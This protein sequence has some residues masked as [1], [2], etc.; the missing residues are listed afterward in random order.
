[1]LLLGKLPLVSSPRVER[2]SRGLIIDSLKVRVQ[3]CLN[4]S[5]PC[6]LGFRYRA[7]A[8][9]PITE[10]THEKHQQIPNNVLYQR[11]R[12]NIFLKND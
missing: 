3:F 5:C 2:Q 12:R 11:S 9:S 8:E 6:P 1:M 4:S 10:V 7:S